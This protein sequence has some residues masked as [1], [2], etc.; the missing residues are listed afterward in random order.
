MKMDDE[1]NKM[2]FKELQKE[3]EWKDELNFEG[4]IV[5]VCPAGNVPCKQK[6]C[7]PFKF[8]LFFNRQK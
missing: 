7:I 3:C 6:N 1:R 4:D 8:G 5:V 2:M